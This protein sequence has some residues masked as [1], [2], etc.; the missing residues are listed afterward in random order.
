MAERVRQ[1]TSDSLQ[2]VSCKLP[3]VF[4]Y[5]LGRSLLVDSHRKDAANL[6]DLARRKLVRE[7]VARVEE[8]QSAM[9]PCIE[10]LG[11]SRNL[12]LLGDGTGEKD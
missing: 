8:S 6:F 3:L 7:P 5:F 11:H 12:E 9:K 4:R 2:P 1:S 10:K